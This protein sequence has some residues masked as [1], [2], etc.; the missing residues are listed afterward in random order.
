M[1]I[2]TKTG[3]VFDLDKVRKSWGLGADAG[4]VIHA[5]IDALEAALGVPEKRMDPGYSERNYHVS[6]WNE[7]IESVRNAAGVT[8]E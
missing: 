4:P 2:P 7:A 8:E 6:G 1:K 5:L 3:G